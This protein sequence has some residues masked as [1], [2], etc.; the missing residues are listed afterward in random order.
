MKI[1][2]KSVLFSLLVLG[3]AS[4]ASQGSGCYDFGSVHKDQSIE[5]CADENSTIIFTS[6][7]AKP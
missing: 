7:I 4:C 5:K 1:T 2:I 3:F 6:V